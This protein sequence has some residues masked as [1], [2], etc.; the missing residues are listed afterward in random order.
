MGK[1][2]AYLAASKRHGETRDDAVAKQKALGKKKMT[3]TQEAALEEKK[4]QEAVVM[5]RAA[6]ATAACA[7]EKK[8]RQRVVEEEQLGR[9]ARV[10]Q[11]KKG[12]R[13]ASHKT[14]SRLKKKQKTT[15]HQNSNPEDEMRM[16]NA[17][18]LLRLLRFQHQVVNFLK[19]LQ[20]LPIHGTP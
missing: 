14:K 17:I 3:K 15:T 20:L 7:G 10:V 11:T 1:D 12:K 5:A 13:A 8:G 2:A 16:M 18:A 6:A 19:L 4:A 9:D